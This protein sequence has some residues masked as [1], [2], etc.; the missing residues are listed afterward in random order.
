MAE[1]YPRK[2]S[3]AHGSCSGPDEVEQLSRG[4]PW[5]LINVDVSRSFNLK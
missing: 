3:N 2:C 4:H 1:V 5:K